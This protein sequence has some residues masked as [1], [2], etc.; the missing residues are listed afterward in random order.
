MTTI[1]KPLTACGVYRLL[2]P[3]QGIS[4]NWIGS[5]VGASFVRC[6]IKLNQSLKP[7]RINTV[8]ALA[9]DLAAELALKYTPF[10]SRDGGYV[11][12]DIPRTERQILA[13]SDYI[14]LLC[15]SDDSIIRE[16]SL[17]PDGAYG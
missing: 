15:H 1:G 12:I 7:Q 11:A 4:A 8:K 5:L 17:T 2:S 14:P 6:H 16:N 10:I 9:E 3:R 13:F